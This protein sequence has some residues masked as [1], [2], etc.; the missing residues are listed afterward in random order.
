MHSAMTLRCMCPCIVHAMQGGEVSQAQELAEE[1]FVS[2][3][4][5]LPPL[6]ETSLNQ[7]Y[8]AY[9]GLF[10]VI[11]LFGGL[12]SPVLE[13]KLGLGGEQAG[14][15]GGSRDVPDIRGPPALG[16]PSSPCKILLKGCA[17]GETA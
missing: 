13:L 5:F 11:I 15:A 4:P 6:D 8:Y 1:K 10:A 3:L 16:M 7:Y 14:D 17:P 12:V 9:A 2:A